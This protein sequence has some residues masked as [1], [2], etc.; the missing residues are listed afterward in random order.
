MH[1]SPVQMRVIANLVERERRAFLIRRW[2]CLPRGSLAIAVGYVQSSDQPVGTRDHNTT[3]LLHGLCQQLALQQTRLRRVW[4]LPG[5]NI[6][7]S[8]LTAQ[9]DVYI[10]IYN[11]N[12]INIWVSTDLHF[13]VR[14]LMINARKEHSRLRGLSV[15]G[16]TFSYRLVQN[17]AHLTR[18]RKRRSAIQSYRHI[19]RF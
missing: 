14:M 10:Y 15:E 16:D 5:C 7:S 6:L 12:N 18:D 4:Y 13:D 1:S 17:R 11:I 9:H 8:R 3:L 2:Y 19:M